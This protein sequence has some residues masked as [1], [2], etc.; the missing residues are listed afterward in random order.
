[1]AGKPSFV[2]CRIFQ[3]SGQGPKNGEQHGAQFIEE[4]WEDEEEEVVI[5][6]GQALDDAKANDGAYLGTDDLEQVCGAL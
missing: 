4:E 1:M 5:T 6:V 2:L 3:K